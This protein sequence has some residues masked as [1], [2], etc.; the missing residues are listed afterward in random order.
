MK[1]IENLF[2]ITVE[3]Q[4]MDTHILEPFELQTSAI[5]LVCDSDHHL[6]RRPFEDST[7]LNHLNTELVCNSDAHHWKL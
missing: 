6:N 7:A 3:I 2:S 1:Y 4:V 5:S